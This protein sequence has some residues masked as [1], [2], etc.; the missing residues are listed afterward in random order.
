M[1]FTSPRATY[2]ETLA[3][4]N[5]V[6]EAGG[7]NPLDAL[8]PAVPSD[9]HKCLI[10]KNLNFNCG[11]G[12]LEWK[13]ND[14][15][16]GDVGNGWYMRVFDKETAH[17]IAESLELPIFWDGPETPEEKADFAEM[18]DEG[19][20]VDP[21]AWAM[22]LPRQ[23]GCVARDFD[24]WNMVIESQYDSES[25]KLE[26]FI[27]P[28]A[29]PTEMEMLQSFWPYVDASEREAYANATFINDKG[30]LIL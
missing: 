5:A 6:R 9:P 22:R 28:D 17:R 8:M 25:K 12:G 19:F 21:G 1:T 11:V 20:A 10:A 3:F 27:P 30:E 13:Q 2:E 4:A 29:D 14:M 15:G 23:I 26:H 24:Q 16:D 7:G 18:R